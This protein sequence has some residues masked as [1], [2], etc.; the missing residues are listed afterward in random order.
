M[1]KPGTPPSSITAWVLTDGKAGDE[2]QCIGVVEALGATPEIRRVRPRAPYAWLMPWG[3]MDPR[4]APDRPGS[5][6]AP[7]WPDLVVASGRRAAPSLRAIAKASGGRTMTVFLKDPRTGA[8]AADLIWVPAHDRLRGGNVLVTVTPPHRV[9]AARL[10]R[11]RSSPDARFGHLPEPRVGVLL[12]GDSR[13]HRFSPQDVARLIGDLSR[14][15]AEGASLLV[16]ASRRTPPALREALIE[17]T[18]RYEGFFWNGEGENPYVAILAAAD[19]LVV[20]AD[21]Y[22]MVGEAAAT[23]RPVLVFEPSGGHPKITAFLKSLEHDG[24]VKPFRGRLERFSYEPLDSTPIIAAA[25]AERL[26]ARR[27]RAVSRPGAGESDAGLSS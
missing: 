25:I 23:G 14:L 17:L 11:A 15:A 22:N 18:K 21:S 24:V 19:A 27:H 1:E 12:G 8:G 5:P 2:Q 3:P 26:A 10:A 4:E 16:T 13:H 7:P 6:L 9:S 20:T